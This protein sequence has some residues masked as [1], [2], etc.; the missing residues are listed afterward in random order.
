MRKLFF[1][2][3][4]LLI[5]LNALSQKY[6]VDVRSVNNSNYPEIKGKL[7]LRNPEVVK[8]D[9][10][11][12]YEDDKA[13]E[14]QFETFQR[15]D[16]V[17]KNKV[18]LFLIR[19]SASTTEMK[20][21]KDVLKNAFNKGAIK[22]GDKIEIVSF[23]CLINK[24]IIFPSKFNFT[25]KA[26]D[27]LA[28][29]DQIQESKYL[30]IGG[31]VQTHIAINEALSLL[32]AENLPFPTG[33]F[34]LSDDHSLLPGLTGELPGPRSRRL[35]IPI[36]GIS[37][38]ESSTYYDIEELCKQTYGCYYSNKSNEIQV[39]SKELTSYLTEFQERFAGLYYPFTYTSTFEKDGK[40]H[41]VKI[42]S[43]GGQSA[44]SLAVP[45]KNIVEL[46]KDNLIVSIILFLF[47]VF[48]AIMIAMLNKKNKLKKQALEVQR[49]NQ[50]TSMEQ[51]QKSAEQKMSQQEI[52]LQ[53]IK[54]HERQVLEAT[55]RQQESQDK[56]KSDEIQLQKMLERGNL[57]WFEFSFGNESGNYQ[58][59][60]PNLTAGRDADNVWT[61]NHSTVSRNHFQLTFKD[62]VYTIRDLGS[63]NGV[64]VNNVKV[65]EVALKHGDCIQVGEITLTFHI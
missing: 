12:F 8:T 50:L 25:D 59:Q 23:S 54:D 13:I 52:E 63:S 58:I 44:F 51:S 57:P 42:D 27:L 45:Q 20:W 47:F 38:F 3:V 43:K 62:Y 41:I 1:F 48:L 29:I 14:V 61:I 30:E 24:Q 49:T 7:L 11:K 4:L 6:E 17:A 22:A 35:N 60:T 16:S 40:N 36:Y 28:R 10:I 19:N 39:V 2:L 18:I 64:I 21:Y 55:L 31:K 65:S 46:I 32:E 53:K 33:I 9:A 26:E 5:S 34:V 15:V 37:H 56:S